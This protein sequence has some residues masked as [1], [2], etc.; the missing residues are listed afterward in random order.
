MRAAASR[1]AVRHAAACD[2]PGICDPGRPPPSC[3]VTDAL[4]WED[5]PY[6]LYLWDLDRIGKR[7]YYFNIADNIVLSAERFVW[8]DL[9]VDVLIDAAGLPRILD[10]HELPPGLA[11]DLSRYIRNATDRLVTGF[12]DIIEEANGR[13]RAV[14]R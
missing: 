5:R 6:T 13:L 14:R 12:R 8:R 4:F 11:E 10:E 2:R 1:T 3:D 7:I 9:A